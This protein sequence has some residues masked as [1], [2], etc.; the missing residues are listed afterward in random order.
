[1]K[2]P[3]LS[4]FVVPFIWKCDYW[5]LQQNQT[6]QKQFPISWRHR[7]DPCASKVVTCWDFRH[8]KEG[9]WLCILQSRTFSWLERSWKLFQQMDLLYILQQQ[10]L[11]AW[12]SLDVSQQRWI[13]EVARCNMVVD[14]S[15]SFVLLVYRVGGNQRIVLK[16]QY[17]KCLQ[18]DSTDPITVALI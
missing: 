13:T 14:D 16:W 8:D 17:S 1:M 3:V 5:L 11:K 6:Q 4:S 9:W 2:C 10:T 18:A 15:P 7:P 12:T